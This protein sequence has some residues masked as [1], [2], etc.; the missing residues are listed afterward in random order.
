MM[1]LFLNSLINRAKR[2]ISSNSNQIVTPN[3]DKMITTTTTGIKIFSISIITKFFC[4]CSLVDDNV[5]SQAI[6]T[7]DEL[8]WCLE[9]L[10]TMQTHKSVSDL[11]SLKVFSFLN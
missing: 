11:A 7:L 9:Q 1:F 6:T 4:F 10:E 3:C 5:L 8:D 2:I